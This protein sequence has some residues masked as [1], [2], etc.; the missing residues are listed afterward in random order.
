MLE[1]TAQLRAVRRLPREIELVAE[2]LLELA[3]DRPRPQALAV[4]PQLLDQ[5]G[6]R[7]Q[8]RDV[9]LDHLRDIRPQHLDGHRRA[10]RQ[11]REM[12]LRDRC[13]RDG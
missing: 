3:D 6:A 1:I 9:L 2:G 11:F 7:V 4:G 12:D 10:V 5:Q 8:E 13:A